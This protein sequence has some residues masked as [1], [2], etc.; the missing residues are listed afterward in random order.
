MN[1]PNKIINTKK[2]LKKIASDKLPS[3]NYVTTSTANIPFASSTE[4]PI[5]INT[6]ITP[7]TE[8]TTKDILNIP[9]EQKK[10]AIKTAKASKIIAKNI[11]KVESVSQQKSDE[12]QAKIAKEIKPEI[13]KKLD[14]KNTDYH[15]LPKSQ[16]REIF[17]H[18]AYPYNEKMTEKDYQTLVL[19]L[20]IELV[21]MQKWV[22][23]T[24]QKI[25]IIFE[26]RDAAGKGGTIKRFLQHL[27]PR[28][29]RVV[30]LEKPSEIEKGQWFFQ[31]YIAQL[32]TAGEIVFFDRSW[33]NRAGVE[34]VMGFC[35]AQDYLE[36][37]RQTPELERM[38]VR[39]GCY[40][41]KLW[42]SVSRAEQRKRF[43]SRS[44]DLLKQW[45]LSPID[46]VAIEKWDEY[47]K[48][49]EAMFFHTDTADAGWTVI[50]SDDKKR[51]R[52]NAI[53]HVLNTIPYSHKNPTV[54]HQTDPLIVGP[55]LLV[56]DEK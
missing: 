56:Y 2:Q 50:K 31:R 14:I 4:M 45:K 44:D 22:K 55:A 46:Q 10:I 16:L 25:I 40:L 11:A 7:T 53:L 51:A 19:P 35:T 6:S 34:H 28:G 20:H 29:A 49:K 21:K 37:M 43:I 32:P 13:I 47:T 15:K 3:N 12:I 8:T 39:S 24:G 52:L 26:G 17:R 1:P 54:V 41:I 33:Y 30:A 42:F 36:F 48:A 18:H 38:L 27:N 5:F 23:S 9:K